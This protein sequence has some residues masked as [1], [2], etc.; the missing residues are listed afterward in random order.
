M[1]PARRTFNIDSLIEFRTFEND[2]NIPNAMRASIEDDVTI[3]RLEGE[4]DLNHSPKLRTLFHG[5]IQAKCPALLLDFSKVNYIDSS[6]LATLVEYYQG[7]RAYSG[8]IALAAMSARVV[9]PVNDLTM[10]DSSA[11]TP[12]K[13]AGRNSFI[14]S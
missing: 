4:I 13:S 10:L 8:K 6:G 2:P 12:P 11:T 1:D 9:A 5:K 7:S 3:L 14:R